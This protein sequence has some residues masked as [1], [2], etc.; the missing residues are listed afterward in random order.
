M[1]EAG[2]HAALHALGGL[3]RQL[4]D[5]QQSEAAEEDSTAAGPHADEVIGDGTTALARRGMHGLPA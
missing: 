3:Y 4:W 2:S 5:L 1:S